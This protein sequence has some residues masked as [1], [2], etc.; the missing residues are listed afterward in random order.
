MTDVNRT[1]L[2][3]LLGCSLPTINS[4]V[5]SGMPYVQKGGRGKEWIFDTSEVIDW[6]KNHAVSNAV[7]DL[8][9]VDAD[10]M[11]LRKL[12]A[13]TTIVE[14]EAAKQKGEVAPVEDFEKATRDLCI[15]LS[16]LMLLVPQRAASD[17]PEMKRIIEKE[18]KEALTD[19]LGIELDYES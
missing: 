13:E 12:A 3:N 7:G 10:E 14:I 19:A 8:S 4:K 17:N 5:S 18:I 16:S 15:E 11:K 2:S 1:E 9:K 6:E